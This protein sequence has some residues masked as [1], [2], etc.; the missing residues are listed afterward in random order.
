MLNSEAETP[1]YINC[2][3]PAISLK[4][5]LANSKRLKD[6]TEIAVAPANS[7]GKD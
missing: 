2:Y 3:T 4:L 6:E 5:A 7:R 1:S